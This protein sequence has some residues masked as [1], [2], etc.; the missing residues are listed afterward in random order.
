MKWVD[1]TTLYIV[2]LGDLHFEPLLKQG[3]EKVSV[4][5]LICNA[6]D[7][8]RFTLR[9]FSIAKGGHTP[10]DKHLGEHE[11]FVLRGKA[12]LKGPELQRFVK[13]GDAIFVASNEVHQFVNITSEPFEFLSVRGADWLYAL[14]PHV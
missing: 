1:W 8:Q 13:P 11:V 5:R 9:Y 14:V 3:A 7:T 2:N 10:L 12:L 6:T 4:K